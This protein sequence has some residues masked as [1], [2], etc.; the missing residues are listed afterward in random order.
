MMTKAKVIFDICR[1]VWRKYLSISRNKHILKCV[2]HKRLGIC[3]KL[4]MS[5]GSFLFFRWI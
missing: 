2:G 3:I 1:R 5:V 4:E